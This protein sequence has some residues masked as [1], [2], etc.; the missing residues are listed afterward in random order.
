MATG[1]QLLSLLRAMR[2]ALDDG[3]LAS[4]RKTSTSAVEITAM[5][6]GEDTFYIALIAHMLSKLLSRSHY[7]DL[8]QKKRFAKTALRKVDKCVTAVEKQDMQAYS[9]TVRDIVSDMR[10]LEVTDPRYV[11][12]VEAKARTKLAS[13][14]YAQG[15][16]LSRAVAITGASKR[17]L[18]AYSGRTLIADRTGKTKTLEERLKH[19][20]EL[21]SSPIIADGNGAWSC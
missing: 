3:D 15:F 4:L 20:R 18:Q 13:R 19:L 2:R 12:D 7:W 17:D 14:L 8:K 11:N 5:D 10:D 1:E 9:K 21:F 6:D 16:S